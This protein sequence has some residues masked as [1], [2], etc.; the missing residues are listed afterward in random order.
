MRTILTLKTLQIWFVTNNLTRTKY[1]K[2]LTWTPPTNVAPYL[3]IVNTLQKREDSQEE[4][5]P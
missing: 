4:N 5:K 3:C 2:S 1:F